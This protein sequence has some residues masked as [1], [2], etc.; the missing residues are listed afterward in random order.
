MAEIQWVIEARCVNTL[1]ADVKVSE[2]GIHFCVQVPDRT[3]DPHEF[4]KVIEALEEAARIG[5]AHRQQEQKL[6]APLDEADLDLE[7]EMGTCVEIG[8]QPDLYTA[9]TLRDG[10][11]ILLNIPGAVLAPSELERLIIEL[12]AIERRM[13]AAR[14]SAEFE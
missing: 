13:L 12:T 4:G 7:L 14:A 5:R 6:A 2:R 1:L 8:W 10:Q 11:L 9:T 3:L